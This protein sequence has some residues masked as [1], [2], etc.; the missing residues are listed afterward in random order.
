MSASFFLPPLSLSLFLTPPQIF[1][2][3]QLTKE[4]EKDEER[5]DSSTEGVCVCVHACVCVCVCRCE[6]V[7]EC[8][9]ECVCMCV[10]IHGCV[11]VHAC[12]IVCVMAHAHACVVCKHYRC[13]TLFWCSSYTC[14]NILYHVVSY[15]VNYIHVHVCS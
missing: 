9:H 8:V 5:A 13:R 15:F 7:R 14:Y 11:F 3:F 1:Q 10:C 2:W 4:E 12:V 6:C